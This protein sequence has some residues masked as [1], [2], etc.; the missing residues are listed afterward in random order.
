MEGPA[1]VDATSA[2]EYTRRRR[3]HTAWSMARVQR[4][5]GSGGAIGDAGFGRD[6]CLGTKKIG[7]SGGA[8]GDAGFDYPPPPKLLLPTQPPIPLKHKNMACFNEMTHINFGTLT[9]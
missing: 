7:K 6:G 1:A 4:A 5:R 2:W 3:I 8:I 9:R